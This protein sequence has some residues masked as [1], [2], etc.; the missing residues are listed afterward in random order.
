MN[1]KGLDQS[2]LFLLRIIK[3]FKKYI[4]SEWT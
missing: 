1:L 2:S 4:W 3:E